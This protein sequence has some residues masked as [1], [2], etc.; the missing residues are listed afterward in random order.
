[1]SWFLL[2]ILAAFIISQLFTPVFYNRYI[3]YT[4]PGA[5]ILLGSGVRRFSKVAIFVIILLFALIDFHYFTHPTKPRFDKLA[6][7]VKDTKN[8]D[9]YLIN[10]YSTPHFLWES[11]YYGIPAP[12]YLQGDGDL[13]YFVGTALIMEDDIVKSIPENSERVGIIT[14]TSIDEVMVPG[15]TE[16]E[17][18][19][20]DQVNFAW[21]VPVPK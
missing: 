3:L 8:N 14:S 4:I 12:L 6:S 17:R 5:M 2:P 1:M 21:F 13:P 15:Y 11:K 16:S 9:D 10:W 18:K 20:F 19:I 7:Y